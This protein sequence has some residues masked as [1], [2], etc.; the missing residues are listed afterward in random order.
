MEC[1][2]YLL[3]AAGSENQ[4]ES[5]SSFFRARF[6]VHEYG[7]G[8]AG[9]YNSAKMVYVGGAFTTGVHNILEPVVMGASVAFGPKHDQ[10]LSLDKCRSLFFRKQFLVQICQDA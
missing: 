10:I 1:K 6:T 3:S 4:R 5:G 2:R 8:I 9:L 7:Q